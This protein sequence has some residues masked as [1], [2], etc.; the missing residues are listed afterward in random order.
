VKQDEAERLR[1][2]KTHYRGLK[3]VVTSYKKQE[4]EAAKVAR[5]H[6]AEERRKAKKARANELAA[7]RALKKRQR[8][9]VT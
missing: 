4:T 3:A 9:A 6:A 7:A 2:Q 8:D 5:Q 1:L